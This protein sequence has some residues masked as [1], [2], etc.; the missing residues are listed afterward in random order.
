MLGFQAQVDMSRVHE[1]EK[2]TVRIDGIVD[3]EIVKVYPVTFLT[4]R[5]SNETDVPNDGVVQGIMV[6]IYGG[7]TRIVLVSIQ[8]VPIK[9]IT[10]NEKVVHISNSVILIV[11]SDSVVRTRI[12]VFVSVLVLDII[13]GIY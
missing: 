8:D 2:V 5:V 13:R 7:F 10:I 3:D 1:T 4:L 9:V 6:T 11:D 12:V